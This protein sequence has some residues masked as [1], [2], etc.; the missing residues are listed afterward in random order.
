MVWPQD[1][2]AQD[3][4]VWEYDDACGT[5]EWS[6]RCNIGRVVQYGESARGGPNAVAGGADDSGL[7]D[8]TAA[9]KAVV[10]EVSSC[11]SRPKRTIGKGGSVVPGVNVG[12]MIAQESVSQRVRQVSP[13]TMAGFK[14]LLPRWGS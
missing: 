10:S 2:T 8:V 11:W 12:Y 7:V 6:G 13:T 5:V 4:I 14:T 1:G 9:N 3:S